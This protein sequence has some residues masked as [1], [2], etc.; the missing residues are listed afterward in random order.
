MLFLVVVIVTVLLKVV[1]EV[2]DKHEARIQRAER[3]LICYWSLTLL[4][5]P[6]KRNKS[7]DAAAA[8]YKRVNLQCSV[9]S[10][11]TITSRGLEPHIIYIL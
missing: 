10:S 3:C 8:A 11:Q 1:S 2:E 9:V 5:P 7:C 4:P 6:L